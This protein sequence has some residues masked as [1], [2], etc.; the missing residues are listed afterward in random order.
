MESPKCKIC[1]ERHYGLCKTAS[2]DGITVSK[3]KF[4]LP[5][6][7]ILDVN[8]KIAAETVSVKTLRE[9]KKAFD[10]TA[11]QREYMRKRRSKSKI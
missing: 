1:K 9:L 6:P 4:E 3:A 10:R 8:L 11:Y 2:L 7:I 5:K